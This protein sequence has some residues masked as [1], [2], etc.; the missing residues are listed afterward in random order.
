MS[1]Y[2]EATLTTLLQSFAGLVELAAI[3]TANGGQAVRLRDTV[4]AMS[5]GELK[6]MLIAR[7]LADS[8]TRREMAEAA[9]IE[10]PEHPPTLH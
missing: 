9:V 10:P 6:A 4:D 1:D 8:V 2:T 3:E 5:T 7:V